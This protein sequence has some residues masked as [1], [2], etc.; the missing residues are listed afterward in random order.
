MRVVSPS[1][2]WIWK[3]GRGCVGPVVRLDWRPRL[4]DLR[5]RGAS[6]TIGEARASKREQTAAI[7]LRGRCPVFL[8]GPPGD[9]REI[10]GLRRIY[11][12]PDC[13][14]MAFTWMRG[15]EDGDDFVVALQIRKEDQ[16]PA[17]PRGLQPD[18]APA[19]QK[20]PPTF[21]CRPMSL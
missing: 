19:I 9:Q 18:L 14:D 3:A 20:R 11:P 6:Q 16:I 10:H 15:I 7:A 13:G 12:P 21:I 4:K 17:D 5:V 1:V 8:R 2:A